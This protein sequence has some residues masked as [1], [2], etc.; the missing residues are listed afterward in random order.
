MTLFLEG[1]SRQLALLQ[2]LSRF[3][4]VFDQF[5]HSHL[6]LILFVLQLKFVDTFGLS[7][8][9]VIVGGMEVSVE[10]G[11]TSVGVAPNELFWSVEVSIFGGWR[12]LDLAFLQLAVGL[13]DS[14]P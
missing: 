6:F 3:A 1:F 8:L 4:S 5:G 10:L 9:I 7:A 14:L 2:K 11:R 13:H 12:L